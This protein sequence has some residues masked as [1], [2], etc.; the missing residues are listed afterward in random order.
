M[1][2]N[3]LYDYKTPTSWDRIPITMDTSLTTAK[4]ALPSTMWLGGEHPFRDW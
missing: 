1:V 3:L 2:L 4:N